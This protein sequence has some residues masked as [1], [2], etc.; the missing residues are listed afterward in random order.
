MPHFV[1]IHQRFVKE[2]LH[3]LQ[4]L[5]HFLVISSVYVRVKTC[6]TGTAIL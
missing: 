1:K 3:S 2:D 6:S 4:F 5:T